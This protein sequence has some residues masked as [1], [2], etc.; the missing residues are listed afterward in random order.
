MNSPC[1]QDYCVKCVCGCTLI[2]NLLSIVTDSSDCFRSL[3]HAQKTTRNAKVEIYFRIDRSWLPLHA[4]ATATVCMN[5]PLLIGS[6]KHS[7]ITVNY[8]LVEFRKMIFDVETWSPFVNVR[9]ENMVYRKKTFLPDLSLS[10]QLELYLKEGWWIDFF[11]QTIYCRLRSE[12][13]ILLSLAT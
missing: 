8:A 6:V 10:F 11:E 9:L 1:F 7:K 4:W 13:S 3:F 5:S 12:S 2:K